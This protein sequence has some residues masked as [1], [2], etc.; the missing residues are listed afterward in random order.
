MPTDRSDSASQTSP[1]D[2]VDESGEESF[3]ASD[4]PSWGPVTGESKPGPSRE[5]PASSAP[6]LDA[7]DLQGSP[8]QQ[9][10]TVA[11]LVI[12]GSLGEDDVLDLAPKHLAFPVGWGARFG[13][14]CTPR[15]TTYRNIEERKEFS[16]TYPLADDVLLTS[17]AAS[18]RE[19][20]DTKPALRAHPTLEAT[21]IDTPLFAE[22]YL[23]LECRLDRIVD[24][25]GEDAGDGAEDDVAG[26]DSLILGQIVAARA[27]RDALRLRDGQRA[28]TVAR[29]GLPVFLSPDRF[30]RIGESRAFPFPAG[31][32]R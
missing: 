8:W 27:R 14:V 16:V 30:A 13:F 2:P 12:V 5:S 10:Y 19:P 28:E 23:F 9:V 3:P 24:I 32:R 7:L 21:E 15:H 4:P 20:D 25:G 31:F 6:E 26:L 17:L 11:P 22:G 1:L 29:L 18:P